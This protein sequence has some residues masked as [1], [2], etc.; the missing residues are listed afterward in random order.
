MSKGT[1]N[2]THGND[3]DCREDT[4]YDWWHIG[5]GLVMLTIL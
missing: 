2:D 5:T 3:S 4:L 1:G